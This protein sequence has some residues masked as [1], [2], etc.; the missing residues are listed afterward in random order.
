MRVIAVQTPVIQP[1]QPLLPIVQQSLPRPLRD[2]D[3]ICVASKV[4][5]LEQGRIVE[6]AAVEPSPAARQA[7]RL[8]AGKDPE[9]Y[10]RWME[11]ILREADHVFASNVIWL[12][13]K[14]G[15]L[16]ANAGIDMSNAPLGYVVLWPYRPWEWARQFWQDLRTAY[17]I[18]QVGVVLT[19]ARSIPLR[20]GFTGMALAFW[21]FEGLDVQ[22]GKPDIFGRPLQYTER[23]MADGLAAAAVVVG[24]E[25]DERTPFVLIEGAPVTFT[26][27]EL[28]PEEILVSADRDIFSAIY[29]EEF[30]A[31]AGTRPPSAPEITDD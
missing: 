17:G 4:V 24:G 29:N 14:D 19:D 11:L 26:E 9:T 5:A 16:I 15:I 22:R 28:R 25:A 12:T 3:I 13:L 20:R 7:R 18:H 27:R 6:L 31:V 1:H 2:G 23:M 8:D 30:Q 10:A 21:G